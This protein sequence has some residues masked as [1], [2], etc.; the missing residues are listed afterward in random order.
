MHGKIGQV[1]AQGWI[2]KL[3]K[4][5]FRLEHSNTRIILT[6][7]VRWGKRCLGQKR[8]LYIVYIG[9]FLRIRRP[10][11]RLNNRRFTGRRTVAFDRVIPTALPNGNDANDRKHQKS[12]KHQNPPRNFARSL[13]GFGTS[14]DSSA[15]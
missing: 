2:I 5:R 9:V 11:K 10:R 7:T 4:L 15:V 13:R 6:V 3:K 12:A 1:P 8:C 14:A